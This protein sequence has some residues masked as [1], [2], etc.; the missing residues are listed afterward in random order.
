MAGVKTLATRLR[1]TA[2]AAA[3]ATPPMERPAKRQRTTSEEI[4][5]VTDI[6]TGDEMVFAGAQARSQAR[7]RMI[8]GSYFDPAAPMA[9]IR[10]D[11][12]SSLRLATQ[13]EKGGLCVCVRPS[14]ARPGGVGLSAESFEL[15]CIC[16]AEG[17]HTR[18]LD[19]KA[20]GPKRDVEAFLR[21]RENHRRSQP[22]GVHERCLYL[23]CDACALAGDR[24]LSAPRGAVAG[25]GTVAGDAGAGAA[26]VKRERGAG[27]SAVAALAGMV[28]PDRPPVPQHLQVAQA[29]HVRGPG[30]AYV[31]PGELATVII[32]TL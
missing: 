5:Y 6:H 26:V 29:F 14:K 24:W 3:K 15:C 31:K 27:V 1:V 20:R 21:A 19:L 8:A 9:V 11:A 22:A 23:R 30:Y 17:C 2:L 10:A 32:N 16:S 28:V 12:S 4:Y 18:C 13:S 7:G 25:G